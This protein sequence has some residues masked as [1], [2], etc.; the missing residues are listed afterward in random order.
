M[1]IRDSTWDAQ[2][3]VLVAELSGHEDG[4]WH[5]VFNHQG[6]QVV[7]ASEDK[8]ARVWDAQNGALVA[9]LSGHKDSVYRAMFSYDGTQVVTVSQDKTARV[10]KIPNIQELIDRAKERLPRKE[11]TREEKKQFFVDT[12]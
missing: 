11:L 7:T 1:C 8:T 2:S 10:W 6:T 9:E 3:G 5:A 4:V 12:E